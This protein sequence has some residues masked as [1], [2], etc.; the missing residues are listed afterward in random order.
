[1]NE[2]QLKGI[3]KKAVIQGHD[4]TRNIERIYK[5]LRE[6]AEEEFTEDNAPTLDGF[7]LECF[8][9]SQS[10]YYKKQP[11]PPAPNVVNHSRYDIAKT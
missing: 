3:F 1:M 7:L 9:K 8:E 5:L 2:R 6:A 10:I 4:H 11:D